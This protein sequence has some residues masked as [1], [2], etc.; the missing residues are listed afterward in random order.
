MLTPVDNFRSRMRMGY[1][2][3]N[4]DVLWAVPDSILAFDL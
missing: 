3:A 4:V 1:E 2:L